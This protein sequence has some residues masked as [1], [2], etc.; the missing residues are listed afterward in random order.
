MHKR[1]SR[2]EVLTVVISMEAALLLLST[3]WMYLAHIELME[4]L[5]LKDWKLLLIG[6]AVGCATSL[7]SYLIT[8]LGDK[9][10]HRLAWLAAM[11]ELLESTLRPMFANA[12]P[13][14]IL[15][16]SVSSGFCEEVF[17]RGILQSQ[18]GLL[19]ASLIF[20]L[21]HFPG[22]KFIFYV[23]WSFLAGLL[24]GFL[25][26]YYHSLWVAIAAHII[27]NV[28]SISLIRYGGY[29]AEKEAP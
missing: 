13:I 19:I 29:G 2:S 24:F 23:V 5:A 7:S 21:L 4:L 8:R 28:V 10:K 12:L 15:L 6:V 11:D 27:N 17:F 16:I 9:L 3:L 18:F 14:D 25:T 22:K 1:F 26:D 20:A